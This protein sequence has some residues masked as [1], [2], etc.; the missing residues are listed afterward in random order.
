MTLSQIFFQETGLNQQKVE[1]LINETLLDTEDGELYLEST[2]NEALVFDD[3]TLK[4]SS[5]N[6]AKGFGMRAVIGDKSTYS[7][8]STLT[9]ESIENACN[10]VKTIKD[11]YNNHIKLDDN[12]DSGKQ[13]LYTNVNPL[14]QI[15][16]SA[17]IALLQKIDNYLR[18]KN[19]LVK[20]VSVSLLGNWQLIKIIRKGAQHIDDTRPLIRLNISVIT[21]QN[22]KMESGS[23]G[24]GGRYLYD[25]LFMEDTWKKAADKALAQALINLEAKPAPAGQMTV[26]LGSGWPGI[27]LHEA[28]GH[29]LEGDFN[30]KKTS[31]FSNL[32]GEQ[33]AAPE[34]TVIDD[35]TISDRRGSLNIDDEGTKTQRNVLIENG[36]LKSYMQDRMNARLMGKAPTGNGRRESFEHQPLPRMTNTFMLGGKHHPQEIIASIKK[37]IYAVNF[38]GGQV[39]ITSGKFVFSM[40]EAYLVENGK[41]LHPV[42]GATLIGNGPD[43]LTKIKMVG[44]DMALDPGVGTCGKAGQGVPVGVGQ[45]TLLIEGLTVGGTE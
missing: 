36:I 27:L 17:K 34:V 23:H 4:N 21:E 11:G 12:I 37:G 24:L 28:I 8:S 10:I 13:A 2:Y 40:S 41:I 19:P 39:D 43:C 26:V 1:N 6:I 25:L 38:G 44:N 7:H 20:Q 15:D 5:Y 3:S 42:K 14:N 32:M 22:G 33:I 29:G 35:G 9:N 45:P 16:L 30:R 31:A 18:T